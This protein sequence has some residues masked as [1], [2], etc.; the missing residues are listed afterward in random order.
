MREEMTV[1]HLTKIRRFPAIGRVALLMWFLPFQSS[2]P[3]YVRQFLI[4]APA[5]RY[6]GNS[7][8]PIFL[9]NFPEQLK[10]ARYAF[11]C[12]RRLHADP[13]LHP[14]S[15][16]T[17]NQTLENERCRHCELFSRSFFSKL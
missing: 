16:R 10:P 7:G 6:N 3:A 17:T 4:V 8:D 12:R 5:P 13:S 2:L 11:F 14:S 15:P 1:R 9:R